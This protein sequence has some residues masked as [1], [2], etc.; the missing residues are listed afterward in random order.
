MPS[1]SMVLH[2]ATARSSLLA[3]SVDQNP[4]V[5]L[6]V[7]HPGVDRRSASLAKM[8][9]HVQQRLGAP[10]RPLRRDPIEVDESRNVA[11]TAKVPR[12]GASSGRSASR[13]REIG[14]LSNARIANHEF[15]HREGTGGELASCT[16]RGRQAGSIRISSD[17]LEDH[18]L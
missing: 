6:M 18:S 7:G 5:S 10:H 13:V 4:V 14:I 17:R 8:W 11:S 9:Q 2:P 1:A 3:A 16:T 12:P 15:V